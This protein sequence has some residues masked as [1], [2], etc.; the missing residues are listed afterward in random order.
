MIKIAIAG[1]GGFAQYIAHFLTTQTSHPFI[2]LSRNP[3]QA[4]AAKGWQ[5]VRVNYD[6]PAQLRYALAGVDTV[7]STIPGTAELNLIDAAA[8]SHVRRFVPS[9]FEG[10][11]GQALASELLDRGNSSSLARLCHY[12]GH[13]IMDYTV[14]VC[15]IFYE[16]FSPGGMAAFQIGRG[17]HIDNEGSYLLNI[18]AKTAHV[19][20]P[21]ENSARSASICMT[22]AQDAARFIVAALA[23]DRWPTEFRMCGDRTRL[24]DLVRVAESTFGN[25][26]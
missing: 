18:R 23:L 8:Q 10:P 7:I 16:R 17:T 22:S 12:H 9:E 26:P 5:V 24:T 19:L 13:G 4:L 2:I 15:G 21:T 14:F 20:Y 1:S 25:P 6:Q 11:P 3:N